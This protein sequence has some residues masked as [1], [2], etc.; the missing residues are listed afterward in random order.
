MICNTTS[1]IKT[2]RKAKISLIYSYINIAIGYYIINLLTDR[3]LKK[4]YLLSD[5]LT[6]SQLINKIISF[7]PK[8]KF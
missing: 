2:L 6:V 5:L 8:I 3:L 1:T 4:S 7:S